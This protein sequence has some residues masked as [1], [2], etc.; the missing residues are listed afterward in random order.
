MRE[1]RKGG[2]RG[3]G[4]RVVVSSGGNGGECEGEGLVM[5][6][7]GVVRGDGNRKAVKGR[8]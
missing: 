3:D 8:V 6:G 1:K 7:P 4:S 2:F 5:G